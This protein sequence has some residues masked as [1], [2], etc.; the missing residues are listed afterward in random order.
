M[1]N[2]AVGNQGN[3]CEINGKFAFIP[4]IYTG[5]ELALQKIF[6]G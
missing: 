1:R 5:H 2:I 3:F 4:F 6:N